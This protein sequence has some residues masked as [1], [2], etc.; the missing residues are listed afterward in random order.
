MIGLLF[1]K[2][3]C[4]IKWNKS[5]FEKTLIL[6][7]STKE[8][9]RALINGRREK[10]AATQHDSTADKG[11]GLVW[12]L[13]GGPGTGKTVAVES[14]AEVAELPVY[15]MNCADIGTV[16]QVVEDHLSY[17]F[18][19]G[20]TWRCI[21]LLD[22]ADV[23]LEERSKTDLQRSALVSVFLRALEYYNGILILTTRRIV[24]FDEAVK[25]RVQLALLFPPLGP[26]E[27]KKVWRNFLRLVQK[28]DEVEQNLGKLAEIAMNGRQIRDT[29]KTALQ[30]ALQEKKSL[31]YSHIE[32][33]L[34][35]VAHSEYAKDAHEN[36]EEERASATLVNSDAPDME[37]TSFSMYDYQKS[38]MESPGDNNTDV[39]SIVSTDDISQAETI[40]SMVAYQQAATDI[41]KEALMGDDELSETYQEA[42][43]RVGRDRFLRNNCKLLQRLSKD[44]KTSPLL[45]SEHMAIRFLGGHRGSQLICTAICH[46]LAGVEIGHQKQLQL[47]PNED[48]KTMLNRFLDN[49]DSAEQSG[50]FDMTQVLPKYEND[51]DDATGSDD[52]GDKDFEEHGIE[53]LEATVKF[54]VSGP[55][56]QVYK[57]RLREWLHPP[58]LAHVSKQYG[59]QHT[60]FSPKD[61]AS[62]SELTN[63]TDTTNVLTTGDTS[64][65]HGDHHC[66]RAGCRLS[67][68][69]EAASS[70]LPAEK[71]ESGHFLSLKK[72]QGINTSLQAEHTT[73]DPVF[74]LSLPLLVDK[75]LQKLPLPVMEPAVPRGMVRVYWDSVRCNAQSRRQYTDTCTSVAIACLTTMSN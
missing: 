11:S 40:A 54:L 39:E 14:I 62:V 48:K 12:L 67:E 4:E 45:P 32:T 10:E 61:I 58:L 23:F 2:H 5:L 41:I 43:E 1:V 22:E 3:I 64:F 59:A 74:S 24:T 56:F 36:D 66:N 37:V 65:H 47:D 38:L 18:Y 71:D 19:I 68:V 30:L 52:E 6:P 50:G 7:E 33:A 49:M 70:I 55:P 60:G 17:L 63:P 46:D 25:S 20:N 9:I 27:R 29:F 72:L 13:H 35:G 75:I 44:L 69:Q 51:N 21:L 15:Q 34:K 73:H 57:Q 42:L 16:P 8:L 28:E 31:A 26:Q 53:T